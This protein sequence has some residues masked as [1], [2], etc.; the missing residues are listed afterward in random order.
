LVF[1]FRNIRGIIPLQLK[2]P[3]SIEE[4]PKNFNA[5][6]GDGFEHG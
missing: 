4:T 1:I 5:I 3:D 6:A 2:K